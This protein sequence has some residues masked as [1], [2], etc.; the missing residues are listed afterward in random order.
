MTFQCGNKKYH[1][2]EQLPFLWLGGPAENQEAAGVGLSTACSV[3][4]WAEWTQVQVRPCWQSHLQRPGGW[5][6]PSSHF[7]TGFSETCPAGSTLPGWSQWLH[8]QT[9]PIPKASEMLWFRQSSST[10]VQSGRLSWGRMGTGCSFRRR[11][12][13][14][15]PGAPCS[16]AQSPGAFLGISLSWSKH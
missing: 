6:F 13:H 4:E 16:T 15:S 11:K 3:S 12:H 10:T 1:G 7:G 9:S 5:Q 14:C 2:K 8:L